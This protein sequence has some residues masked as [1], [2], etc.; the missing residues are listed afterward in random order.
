ELSFAEA[1]PTGLEN[2]ALLPAG[3]A[4]RDPG[5]LVLSPVWPSF[6]AEAGSQF[7]YILVDTP[8]VLAADDAATLAPKVDGVLFVVRGSF[9]SA[10]M[11]REALDALR[12][13]RA[14]VLGMI[15]NR[16]SS[17]PFGYSHYQKYKNEYRWQPQARAAA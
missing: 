12:Q 17:S 3:E 9:T 8:P 5:E 14:R 13:R 1:V 2:L 15:F 16:A 4:K 7:D 11:V 6:L 10:R